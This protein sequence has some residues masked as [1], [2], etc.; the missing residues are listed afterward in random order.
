M[1]L[2]IILFLFLFAK[3]EDPEVYFVSPDDGDTIS[4]PTF[5][6]ANASDS[7][8]IKE[9]Y[10]SIDGVLIGSD[11]NKPYRVLFDPSIVPSGHHTLTVFA[12]DN[13]GNFGIT[14]INIYTP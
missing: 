10:F 11:T 13:L 9:V 2:L 1:K 7:D 5:L 8:G 12:E 6:H 4:Q 3:V 14:A